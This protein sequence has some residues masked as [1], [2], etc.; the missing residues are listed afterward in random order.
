MIRRLSLPAVLLGAV[1]QLAGL[2]VDAVLHGRDATLAQ[3]EGVLTLANPG[4]L[5]FALGLSLCLAGACLLVLAPLLSR[6]RRRAGG[7]ILAVAPV[8]AVATL[9]IAAFVVVERS[10][11]LSGHQHDTAASVTD[12]GHDAEEHAGAA[13]DPNHNHAHPDATG[14][15]T[16]ATLDAAAHQHGNEVNI[17]WEQIRQIDAYLV[18]AKAATEKYRDV[19]LARADGYRQVTQNVPGLGAHFTHAGLLAQGTFDPER[20]QILLYDQL[21]DGS[22]ELVGVSWALPKRPGNDTPPFPYFGKLATWHY[23]TNLCFGARA[24]SPVVAISTPEGCRA[25]G[26]AHVKETPWMVHAWLFRESPEG[27]F[28]HENSTIKGTQPLAASR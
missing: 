1:L 6:Q 2:M 26:G 7:A 24:G 9:A 14:G 16:A 10:G 11:G 23:H 22:F 20:P 19:R 12:H 8:A 4:H 21:A 25:A 5:L 3:R 17:S 28:S 18:A 15:A 27:V 13:G